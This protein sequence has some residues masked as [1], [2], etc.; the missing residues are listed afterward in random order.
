MISFRVGGAEAMMPL[1][2]AGKPGWC[3]G[4]GYFCWQAAVAESVCFLHNAVHD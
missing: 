2:L 1:V 4:R 3:A